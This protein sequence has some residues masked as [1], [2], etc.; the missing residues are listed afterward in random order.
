M[1][2]LTQS[3]GKKMGQAVF[4]Q[5]A[6][7]SATAA[8][9]ASEQH[10]QKQALI[11][12][13]LLALQFGLQPM[14]AAKFTP[15]GVSKSSVVIA[16]EVFKIVIAALSLLLT[17]SSTEIEKLREQWTLVNSL[18]VAALPA[19]LYA[20]QNLFV[21][22]GYVLLDSMTFNLLNQT[23]TLSAAFWLYLLMGQR[24]S[25]VQMVA[26]MLLLAA[27]KLLVFYRF[28]YPFFGLTRR[29]N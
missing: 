2:G 5:L 19:T 29:L 25:P 23:K 20:I 24:Q 14:I 12:C 1:T 10:N 8:S 11:Y 4:Q 28:F 22:Y 16:T 17:A 27:G 18:Q 15:S 6:S 13:S 3:A 7:T 9:A 26:L 21:Q